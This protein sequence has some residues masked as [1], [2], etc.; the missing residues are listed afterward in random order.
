MGQLAVITCY[1]VSCAVFA[2]MHVKAGNPAV[3]QGKVL[4]DAFQIA[5]FC[6]GRQLK[7]MVADIV[8]CLAGFLNGGA[9]VIVAGLLERKKVIFLLKPCVSVQAVCHEKKHGIKKY[10]NCQKHKTDDDIS[11]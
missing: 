7:K 8:P 4:S 5:V 10:Q 2:E 9:E 6:Q 11:L 3:C 1:T